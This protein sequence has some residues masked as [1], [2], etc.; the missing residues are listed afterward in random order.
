MSLTFKNLQDDLKDEIQE[1][2][3]QKDMTPTRIKRVLNRGYKQIVR[4]TKCLSQALSFTTVANQQYYTS[5]EN[6]NWAY[7]FQII[8]VKY[9]TE[10]TE[11]GKELFPYPGGYN[12]LPRNMSYGEPVY[13][14]TY[15]QQGTPLQK[16]GTY[17]IIDVASETL[18]VNVYH[19]VITELTADSDP[20]LIKDDFRDAIT[21]YAAWKLIKPYGHLNPAWRQKANDN[22]AFYDEFVNSYK[23]NHFQI[24]QMQQVCNVDMES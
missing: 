22:K 17:P 14:Y 13:Y 9:I 16:I 6:S 15:G 7:A 11:F 23:F 5:A 2:L 20:A 24:D 10:S 19:D 12:K 8:D 1:I 3:G 18:S 21:F 4:D